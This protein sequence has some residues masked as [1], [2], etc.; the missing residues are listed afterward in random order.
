MQGD[1]I[2]VVLDPAP[3]SEPQVHRLLQA[4][5]GLGLLSLH[6]KE[7]RGVVQQTGVLRIEPTGA[8][9]FKPP[10]FRFCA[11]AMALRLS[12]RASS[13]LS[14]RWRSI[15]CRAWQ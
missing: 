8:R 6:G 4:V 7:T 12:A 3:Q 13:G 10:P 14:S 15:S 1:E 2:G 5:E 11:A 9:P